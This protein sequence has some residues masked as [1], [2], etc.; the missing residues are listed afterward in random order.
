MPNPPRKNQ[1]LF[2]SAFLL[3]AF[4]YEFLYFVM[5]VHIYDL[6]RSALDVGI[7]TALTFIP[8]LFSS[9]M[10]GIADKIGKE[11]SLAI[12]AVMT[13]ILLL[14]MANV[15]DMAVFQI[16]WF[17]AS[18]FF[19]VIVNARGTLMA[20]VVSSEHYASG[21][22]AALTLLNSAKLL[23]PLLGGL[24]I[25]TL[26]IRLLLYV[27]AAVY[28]L[29]AL[30]SFAIR[31][32]KPAASE[33]M[34]F[35]ANV[36]KG[37]QFMLVNKV[38]GLITS[39]SFFWRLFLGLQ[40]SLFVIYVKSYL[41]CT[42]EQYG[43]FVTL[44]GAGSIVGSLLGPTVAK[45]VKPAWLIAGGLSLHNA[46][47][48]LLGLCKDYALSL[49]IVFVSFVVFYLTLVTLHSVRD[50][51][52]PFE[53]RASAYGTTTAIL[54]P[55]AIVS[56]LAGGFLTDHLGVAQVLLFAGLA[57]LIS[58]GVILYVNRRTVKII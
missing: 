14:F 36:K 30:F 56:T 18:I 5:T 35:L 54:T 52:T 12:S 51:I 45:L 28:L 2:F 55:A 43:F 32:E 6:T 34:G 29:V 16:V 11:K 25:M 33:R 10:G 8:K 9:V 19:T 20:E 53:I 48:A 39:I 15:S 17:F 38:F 13:G 27:T 22:A 31:V 58:L 41:N 37:F 44:A 50:R 7:F 47:F 26:S 23:G 42:S 21:N 3:S 49:V 4:G 40:L 1:L 46:S 57:A 24:I